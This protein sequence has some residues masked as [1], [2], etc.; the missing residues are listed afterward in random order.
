[1][2]KGTEG[3]NEKKFSVTI[4]MEISAV[5]SRKKVMSGI[6]RVIVV[7][8][9]ESEWMDL[10]ALKQRRPVSVDGI[11]SI[12]RNDVGNELRFVRFK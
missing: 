7:D 3:E 9:I 12:M 8:S 5:R 6:M 11:N 1:M 4:S 10:I 2:R